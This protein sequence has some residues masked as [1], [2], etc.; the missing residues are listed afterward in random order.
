[1]QK[2]TIVHL[3]ILS[4]LVLAGLCGCGKQSGPPGEQTAG[5]TEQGSGAGESS[6][7]GQEET[8]GEAEYFINGAGAVVWRGKQ[9]TI[10]FSQIGAESDWRLASSASMENTFRIDNGYNLIFDNAQQKQENQIKAIR[11]FI[12]QGVDYIILDPI[13]ETGWTSSLK[14][15]KEAGIPVIVV[16]REV[17]ADD[18]DLYT[19]WFGS[20]FRLEGDRACMWLKEYLK[21]SGWKK[22]VNIVH[23]QGTIDSSAQIGRS[24]ALFDAAKE[25]GWNLL[26]S[27]CGDFVQ[28][29]GKEVAETALKEFGDEIQVF[30]C[31][32]DNMAYGA[33]EAIEESGRKAGFNLSE[34]EILILSFDS[35]REGLEYTLSHQIAVDTECNPLYGPALSRLILELETSAA[36]SK[37]NYSEE[38]QF[39]AY[40]SISSLTVDN[41]DLP[42][43][44]ITPDLIKKR[45]Y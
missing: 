22:R 21:Q 15:A 11:E 30:Y 8:A 29:K 5:S 28:A 41:Q 16:D 10:G 40:E 37:K 33:I 36:V 34:G 42:V 32:N 26:R 31:E 2:R 7:S 43:T 24:Q 6:A 27:S 14:E 23:I 44:M 1:M 38:E 39:S 25:N 45:I 3:L 13:V 19:A 4:G 35:A 17:R 9:L 18:E 12:D 20:D